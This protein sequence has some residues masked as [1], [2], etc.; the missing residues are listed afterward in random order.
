MT[1]LDIL[2]PLTTQAAQQR[3]W[4]YL[5]RVEALHHEDR[6]VTADVVGTDNVYDVELRHDSSHLRVWCSCPY[7]ADRSTGCKHLWATAVLAVE[8]GWFTNLPPTLDVVMDFAGGEDYVFGVVDED[9]QT[10]I[11]SAVKAPARPVAVDAPDWQRALAA[12]TFRS[13]DLAPTTTG[14]S[15]LL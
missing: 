1:I 4:Q 12:V 14:D 8:H 5:N 6:S 10:D 15:Q 2:R 3:G 13:D 9:D 11:R 7:F